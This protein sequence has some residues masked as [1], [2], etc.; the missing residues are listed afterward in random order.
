MHQYLLVRKGQPYD[1]GAISLLYMYTDWIS[2][3]A[4]PLH[5]CILT[6]FFHMHADWLSFFT[7]MQTDWVFSCMLTDWGSSHACWLSFFT[8]M[9]TDWVFSHTCRLTEFFHACWL[10]EFLHMHACWLRFLTC[11]F[12]MQFLCMH[13][14]W[15]SLFPCM[16][17]D[18][19]FFACILTSDKYFQCE[20]H[21]WR[22]DIAC[23][24]RPLQRKTLQTNRLS[25]LVHLTFPWET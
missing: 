21:R 13:A 7:Y 4:V 10:T 22:N 23:A 1:T 24:N 2:S 15:L 19:T 18:S 8:C 20:W 3:H 9:Q 12:L 25:K 11:M 14:H 16:H 6:E 17:A 5:V